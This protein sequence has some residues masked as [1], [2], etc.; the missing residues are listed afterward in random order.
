LVKLL[1]D[2]T[3]TYKLVNLPIKL[4]YFIFKFDKLANCNTDGSYIF[5]FAISNYYVPWN[6]KF[7]FNS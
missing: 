7:S 5:N 4:S 3:R 1:Y 6:I 2:R